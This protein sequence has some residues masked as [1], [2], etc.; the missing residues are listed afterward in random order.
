MSIARSPEPAAAPNES[1]AVDEATRLLASA[2]RVSM[3]ELPDGALAIEA[4]PGPR[5]IWKIPL[6]VMVFG[7]LGVAGGYLL[8]THNPGLPEGY[9]WRGGWKLMGLGGLLVGTG[10]V[11]LLIFIMQGPP[12]KVSLEAR[13]GG[14]RADRSI[15]GDRVVSNYG[16]P[17]VFSLFVDGGLLFAATRKGEQQ[18]IAFGDREVNV[19]IATLL[20][21]RLWQGEELVSGPAPGVNRWVIGARARTHG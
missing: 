1:S 5:S 15:A 20:A 14:L 6:V 10:P 4:E 8:Q 19:A 9:V 18:L 16:A 11:F 7:A 2:E 21:L 12:R 3:K 13:P 17:D